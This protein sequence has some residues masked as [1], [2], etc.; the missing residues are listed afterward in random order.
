MQ[1]DTIII[2]SGLGGLTAANRLAKFGRKVLLVEQHHT[3]GGLAAY[4]YR[5]GHVFDVSLHGFP[6]GMVKTCRKYWNREIADSIFQLK[7]IVFDNPQFSLETTYD[8]E[9]FKRILTGYFKISGEVVD[10]FFETVNSMDFFDD[11][12][13][14]VE[15]LFERFFPGRSDVVRFLMEPITYANGS[16]L[17]EPAITYGIVFTN[18]MS[19]GVYTV[20]GGTDWVI[21]AMEKELRKNGVE[22]VLQTQVEK[23][24]VKGGKAAGVRA[25]GEEI[26]ARSVLSNANLKATA[27]DLLDA[28]DMPGDFRREAQEV[29]LSNSSCQVYMGIKEGEKIEDIGDLLFTSTAP[30]FDSDLLCSRDVTSRTFSFY[31]PKTRPGQDRYTVVASMNAKNEDWACLSKKDYEASKRELI[32]ESVQMLERYL[33]GVTGKIDY[34]EAA[35]PR[36]FQR[37]TGHWNGASFG[38]KF[39]G[40][41]IS[42]DIS[43]VIEGLFHT[44]STAIIMSGWLGAANYGVIV[45]NNIEEYLEDL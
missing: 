8:T 32:D 45:A 42:T 4:F 39:E 33:P 14:T 1:Y 12:S 11:R 35:T 34:T 36:T 18:F 7:R 17:L 28:G 10:A 9:D 30:R 43:K 22:I 27:L 24:L 3:L 15:G 2:G 23:I 5:R 31:Y 38:S 19:K 37:Y 6:Y 25:G 13:E 41:K 26:T 29:R 20:R 40:L 44:G 16:T 21:K